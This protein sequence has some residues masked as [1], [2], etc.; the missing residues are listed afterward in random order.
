V[1]RAPETCRVILQY[2]KKTA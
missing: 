1:Q 2:N